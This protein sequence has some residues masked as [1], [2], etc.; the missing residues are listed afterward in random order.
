MTRDTEMVGK[1]DPYLELSIGG[2]TVHKTGTKDDAGKNPEWNEEL[3]YEVK[4][5]SLE[6][7]FKVSDEDWGSDDIVGEGT[8][9][10]ADLCQ[11]STDSNYP[12]NFKGE[13][14]GTIRLTS[15]FVN[16]HA[17]KAA[18]AEQEN[19]RLRQEQEAELSA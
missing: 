18:L 3:T 12:I 13:D 16:F 19:E 1:M 8:C 2:V 6:V 7:H 4:D 9:T 14:A 5:M 10:L 17:A 15:R 11:D